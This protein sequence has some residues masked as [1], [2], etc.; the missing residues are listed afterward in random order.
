LVDNGT[1]TIKGLKPGLVYEVQYDMNSVTIQKNSLQA[2]ANGNV[3]II[4]LPF[5]T[6]ENLF[7]VSRGC[8]SNT[9]GPFKL[10]SPDIPATPTVSSNSPLCPGA[11]LQLFA[12][13]T[14]QGAT[15]IWEGPLNFQ[16]TLQN[17]IIPNISS[18]AKGTYYVTALFQGCKSEKK[19]IEISVFND[20]VVD[21]GPNLTLA[22]GTLY[23]LN[24]TIS[25]GPIRD[26]LWTPSTNLSCTVC[27][28]PVVTVKKDQTYKLTV[29]NINGCK[30]SDEIFIK[31]FCENSQVY[32]PNAFTPDGDGNNDIFMV[33]GK[34][35]Q[36]VKTFRIYNRWGTLIFERTNIQPNNPQQGWDG[37]INGTPADIG[38]F[39]YTCEVLCD[40]GTPFFL[41]G[42]VTLL[43]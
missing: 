17:P 41:K 9:I 33:R 2:D 36:E 32:I 12:N 39:A 20:P 35:I 8:P 34:G 6:Y 16:S 37:R 38:V 22:T 31:T 42:N 28:S 4:N 21:L 26:W 14:T 13:S 27:P 29:T 40:N 11:E 15:F 23:Q 19:S 30:G 10:A 5:G 24:P 7:V 1:I 3:L 43:K 18:N 25:F